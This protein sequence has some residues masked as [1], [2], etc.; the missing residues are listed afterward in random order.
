MKFSEQWLREWVSPTLDA[1]GIADQITMAGLEVD[2]VEPAAAEFSGVVI[3]KIVDIAPHPDADKL[4]VCQVD[5]GETVH[6]VVCGAPNAA[7]GLYVALARV[8]AVLPG[9]FKIKKAKLR[10]VPS[11]G[12]L[13]GAS[14]LGLE[15]ETSPGIMSL[16]HDA[17]L[18]QDIREWLHLDDWVI[19]VDL[20][21]NRGDCLSLRGLAREVGVLNRLPVADVVAPELPAESAVDHYAV[22]LDQAP[23]ACSKLLT[24]V[25]DGIDA[26]RPT[27]LWMSER[28][29]RSG[30]R[31]I[32]LIVDVTQYVMLELGQPLHAYDASV[33]AGPLTPRWSRKGET[34]A[35]LNGQSITLDD[36]TLVI[37]D[38]R[39]PQGL[40]GIM[41]GQASG[42]TKAS[43]RI[44]LEAAFFA[45][46]AIAGRARRYGLHTDASHRFE[47]GVD[48]ALQ[49][50]ALLR[51]AA[52]LLALGGGQASAIHEQCCTDH[53][54]VPGTLT[55]AADEVMRG[56]GITL[57]VT[58][59]EDIV[60]RLGLTLKR[61][62]DAQWQMTAPSWRFD[63]AQPADV[64]EEL[65]RV[66]GYQRIPSHAPRASLAPVA[67]PEAQRP[68]SRL[69]QVMMADG[70]SE[71]ITYSFVAPELQA[72]L[73]PHQP[74]PR[75]ANP[76]SADMSVMRSSLW[77]GLCK[78]LVYNLNR[79]Q[80]RVALFEAG[81]VFQGESVDDLAQVD[82]LGGVLCGT[83]HPTGW[84]Q[85]DEAAD[86]FDMKGTVER[87]LAQGHPD[88]TQWRFVAETHP[89]L[90][91][92]QSARIYKRSADGSARAI[93]W[94]G[95]MH[96]E[97]ARALGI[98]QPVY[99]FEM[100]VA[101]L[102]K[103]ML[104]RGRMLSRYPEVR[105]DLAFVV[106]DDVPVADMLDVLHA[107]GG[108]A[109][110][111]VALF[112]VYAGKGIEPGHKSLA[113]TLSWQHTERTLKDEEIEQWVSSAVE[114]VSSR[115]GATLRS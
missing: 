28:L 30:I 39:G 60:T 17:P 84:N 22:C 48:P 79:Q 23:E 46:I 108:E 109:L 102:L 8:G 56:L 20:T 97:V 88:A 26:T 15:E 43:T 103:G 40:A 24:C 50:A 92:G 110:T 115:Y 52:L 10:G 44:V 107:E 81:Q 63:I 93:G 11:N 14:E 5:D 27:P 21:P 33:L 91:P 45:P 42:V 2:G 19:D 77:P 12:M 73:Q 75:L 100:E 64:I 104:P 114:A 66:Y 31:S 34:L 101:P 38:D 98:Q 61:E 96:P 89:A 41:G 69:K 35:L 37:A 16:P 78:A 90:H 1:Q 49:R 87:V 51:A 76:L 59:I 99:L 86:F 80:T 53:L 18:G 58:E 106:K 25:I 83:R 105:R 111:D 113:L 6:Q 112:D 72:R 68:L 71:A 29:R 57:D 74:A 36:D 4:R 65:A 82:Y 3:A 47:R 67:S 94:L 55:F 13:C 32:D 95:T 70:F 54:P 62:G 85:S 7:A 9:N